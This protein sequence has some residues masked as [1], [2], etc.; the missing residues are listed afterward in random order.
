MSNSAALAKYHRELNRV[1]SAHKTAPSTK[2]SWLAREKNINRSMRIIPGLVVRIEYSPLQ[3]PDF[4]T[5]MS[6]FA[7]DFAEAWAS[8]M[9]Y[10]IGVLGINS[11]MEVA[12]THNNTGGMW[13]GLTAIGRKNGARIEFRKGSYSSAFVRKAGKQKATDS[14]M[15]H[16]AKMLR[17]QIDP[18]TGKSKNPRVRNRHKAKT[19]QHHINTQLL[20]PTPLELNAMAKFFDAGFLRIVGGKW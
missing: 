20:A 13:R 16:A 17:R 15:K 9:K 8:T 12:D 18:K 2:N 3:V 19:V 7:L 1:R 11:K 5:N 14:Q 4:I 10:R 6:R